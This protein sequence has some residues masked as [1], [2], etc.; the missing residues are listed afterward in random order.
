LIRKVYYIILPVVLF[1]FFI[2]RFL[3]PELSKDSRC[4]IYKEF[5][6]IGL[7]GVVLKKYIDS[8]QHSFPTVEIKNL[9]DFKIEILNLNL[10]TSGIYNKINLNDTLSKETG[11]DE[12]FVIKGKEKVLLSR[13][14]FG[15]SNR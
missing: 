15:C 3:I 6:K 5:L 8:S 13:I 12:V 4:I 11:K 2:I 7:D 1:L 9:N 10:D 14:D